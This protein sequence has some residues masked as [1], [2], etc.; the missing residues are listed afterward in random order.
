ML[1]YL[2]LLAVI[3][4]KLS[5]LLTSEPVAGWDTVP[6]LYLTNLMSSY[7]S[8][9]KI[10]GLDENWYAGYPAFTLYPPLGY[11][12]LLLPW[13][14]SFGEIGVTLSFNLMLY[15][16]PFILLISAIYIGQK[17]GSPEGGFLAALSYLL[18][19]GIL[20]NFGNGVYGF[21]VTGNVHGLT[22]FIILLFLLDE[23]F[24]KER[25]LKLSILSAALILT[26]LLS[27]VFFFFIL[28]IRFFTSSK[29][30]S[31][32]FSV[33]F[34]LILTSFWTIP[35]L[36]H[37][38]KSSGEMIGAFKDPIFLILHDLSP[39]Y[40]NRLIWIINKIN[41]YE[42]L[43]GL[44][45]IS[46]FV[47]VVFVLYIKK[48]KV[49][50]L[51]L[52]FAA[53]LILLP[54][55]I[56][57]E[58]FDTAIHYY[59]FSPMF[60]VFI[61][62]MASR[63][64]IKHLYFLPA[65]LLILLVRFDIKSPTKLDPHMP[66]PGKLSDAPGIR[67][68][69]E[70]VSYFRE[71]PPKGRVIEEVVSSN[72][73]YFG[74]PHIFSTRLPLELQIKMGTG[75]LAESALCSEAFQ[76]PL[77]ALTRHEIWGGGGRW[78]NKSFMLQPSSIQIQRLQFLGV[79]HVIVS[80]TRGKRI[81]GRFK[82]IKKVYSSRNTEV[83]ELPDREFKF[84]PYEL[85]VME[86]SKFEAAKSVFFNQNLLS[87]LPVIDPQGIDIKGILLVPGLTEPKIVE[88]KKAKLQ[89]EGYEVKV[90]WGPLDRIDL[91]LKGEIPIKERL[92]YRNRLGILPPCFT[93][94]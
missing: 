11:I 4:F 44:P 37:L 78:L 69:N 18:I 93:L 77:A 60:W 85:L 16:L 17:R 28:F 36:E 19:P 47:L 10:S 5:Y 88:Q 8:E 33:F 87:A 41:F 45:W 1:L 21:L 32:I 2:P 22:G 70:I 58:F 40:L 62:L 56:F 50:H 92:S 49:D 38:P 29:K 74:S 34:T 86:G 7:L 73:S 14:I 54:R 79:S 26:H 59:R 89:Q 76:A 24:G 94:G 42:I 27:A 30:I 31:L 84:S 75:L 67:T 65:F 71:N 82:E 81:L 23:L 61:I 15:S 35:F 46:I 6:H 57:T 80:S 90:L 72:L 68:A 20:G 48:H 63:I 9:G 83:F 3:A 25:V 55:N 52:C 12:V 91:K 51:A 53:S 64:K 39:D 43:A 66:F 13:L